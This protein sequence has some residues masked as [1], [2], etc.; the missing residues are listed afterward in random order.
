MV[1]KRDPDGPVRVVQ[2][3]GASR[4]IHCTAVGKALAAWLPPHELEAIVA[5]TVF[6]RKT[7]RTIR[8]AAAFR[9]ELARIR[10]QGVAIDYEEHIE[11]IR[12]LAVPVRDHSGEVSAALC[13][14]GPRNGMPQRRFRELREILVAAATRLSAQLGHRGP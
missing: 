2:D 14:L 5:R 6:E 3:V 13:V 4:P 9:R 1:A 8:T 11:G 7:A 10:R 12:C